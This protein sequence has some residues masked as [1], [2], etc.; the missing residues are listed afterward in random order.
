VSDPSQSLELRPF[1]MLQRIMC[2]LAAIR[3]SV[4]YVEYVASRLDSTFDERLMAEIMQ[5]ETYNSNMQS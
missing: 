1:Q 2:E 5:Q 4:L 3:R